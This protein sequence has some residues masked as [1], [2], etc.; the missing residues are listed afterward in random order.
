MRPTFSLFLLAPTGCLTVPVEYTGEDNPTIDHDRDGFVELPSDGKPADCAP[1][2]PARFPTAPEFCDGRWNNCATQDSWG[3][4]LEAGTVTFFDLKG[5]PADLTDAWKQAATTRNPLRVTLDEPGTLSVCGG[6][7]PVSIAVTSADVHLQ[8]LGTDEAPAVLS[9]AG[10]STVVHI[11][12]PGAVHI[13]GLQISDGVG[14]AASPAGGIQVDRG[15]VQLT[16][17]TL[18]GNKGQAGG[19]IH[20]VDQLALFDVRVEGNEAT[21]GHGGGIFVAESGQL[22]ADGLHATDNHTVVGLRDLADSPRGGAI[23]NLGT[24]T[25]RRST[26][27]TSVA[28]GGGGIYNA[29]ELDLS[30]T[31]LRDNYGGEGGAVSTTAGS[32]TRI[33]RTTM[34][35]NTIGGGGDGGA[36]FNAGDTSL[37]DSDLVFNWAADRGGGVFNASTG[38]L[39]VTGTTLASN[40]ALEGGNFTDEGTST[41]SDCLLTA[42]I[43]QTGG[44]LYTNQHGHT[45]LHDVAIWSN[46]ARPDDPG[47]GDDGHGG[48]GVAVRGGTLV[49]TA[50]E[51]FRGPDEELAPVFTANTSDAVPAGAMVVAEA[52]DLQTFVNFDGCSFGG[53]DQANTPVTVHLAFR[54]VQYALEGFGGELVC[55]LDRCTC[56][57]G[58]CP[59][60]DDTV[61]P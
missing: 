60:P 36:L 57:G 19:G 32:T 29:G 30:D 55:D 52:I 23:A 9:G 49:C 51:D 12:A 2:D 17:S 58:D 20:V 38:T 26:L 22:W 42:G 46:R 33:W 54:G 34:S 59:T 39:A 24:A 7:W 56:D 10:Q 3:S 16:A 27:S 44:G 31:S 28:T 41:W 53:G 47:T 40:F 14:T 48:G 25:V 35:G 8:G 18:S 45:T 1:D 21:V 15:V 43:A 61:T 6:E 5:R 13:E 37:A 4:T 50:S 11:D